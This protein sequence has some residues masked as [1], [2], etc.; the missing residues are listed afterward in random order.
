MS[1]VAYQA[2]FTLDACRLIVKATELGFVVT[3]GECH[4]PQEMQDIYV[5][6][7]RSKTRTSQHGK[8]LAIDL[9]LFRDG[10][11][12]T[13]EQVKPLG[14]WWEAQHPKNRWGGNWRGQVD[15]HKSSFIDVPHFERMDA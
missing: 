11:L 3:F 10:K 9:N 5:R 15:A 14:D 13:R 4:R 1:L 8:R 7:G 6:T 2:E 12:C